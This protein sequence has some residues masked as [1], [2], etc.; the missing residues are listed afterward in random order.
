MA[1]HKFAVEGVP[2]TTRTT[3]PYVIVCKF[4]EGGAEIG[5][6]AHSTSAA[7]TRATSLTRKHRH[8]HVVVTIQANLPL[9]V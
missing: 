1:T 5:G 3:A 2:L 8:G 7:H 6:Y 9:V 4:R